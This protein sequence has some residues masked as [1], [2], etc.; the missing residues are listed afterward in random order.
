VYDFL[1]LFNSNYG[2][3]LHLSDIDLENTATLQSRSGVT[4]VPFDSLSSDCSIL[5]QL[6]QSYCRQNAPFFSNSPSKSYRESVTLKLGLRVSHDV[7]AYEW[8]HSIDR[9]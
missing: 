2:S 7:I 9:I 8:H 4:Q 6:L 1:L 3:I 5:K